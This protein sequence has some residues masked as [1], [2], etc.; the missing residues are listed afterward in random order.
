MINFGLVTEGI[1]DQEVISNILLN[2]NHF[3]MK[4]IKI[5]LLILAVGVT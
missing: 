1:T 3:E 2:F 4:Q 5:S